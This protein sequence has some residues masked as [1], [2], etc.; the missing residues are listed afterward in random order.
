MHP[1][2]NFE[3]EITEQYQL[4]NFDFRGKLHELLIQYLSI[5]KK[6]HD[7]LMWIGC[8]LPY[9]SPVRKATLKSIETMVAVERNQERLNFQTMME[10]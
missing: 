6:E 9:S 8:N 3:N 1:N 10:L 7:V 5:T 2:Y 4:K